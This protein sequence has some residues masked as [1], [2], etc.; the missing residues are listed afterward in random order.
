MSLAT[1]YSRAQTGLAAPLVSVEV[2]LANGL[3][4][5]SIVGLPEAAVRES[6][7]RVRAAII[8]AKF[9]FPARRI[10]VNLA[11][12]D[13]PKD[14]GR[15]DLP[16]AL[17]LLAASSQLPLAAPEGYEFV[18]ELSLSGLVRK[19]IGVLPAAYACHQA[20]TSLITSAENETELYR[21]QD[22]NIYCARHLLEVCAHLNNLQ[23]LPRISNAN[24]ANNK[25]TYP[26][27]K[28]V[29]GQQRAKRALCI[30]AAGQHHMLM[31]GSPGSGKTMLAMRLP[32]LLAPMHQ[33][34]IL[35]TC[36]IYSIANA[37]GTPRHPHARPFRNPHHTV[38]AVGLAGGGSY[39][40]P[41]EISLAH[42][43]VLFLDEFTEFDRRALEILREPLESGKITISR[44]AAQVEFPAR[45]QLIAAMNPCPKGCD[46]DQFGQCGCSGTE[47][48]S[49]RKKISAPLLD[50]I[51]LQ[52]NVPKL[53]SKMLLENRSREDENWPHIQE[54]VITAFNLQLE[55][56][57][58]PNARLQ[59]ELLQKICALNFS[60]KKLALDI[61]ERLEISAR[62]FHGILKV[63]RTL[64]D[65]ECSTD[66]KATHVTEAVSYR[67]FDRTLKL[68]Q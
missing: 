18:G 24:H 43:G 3:P 53:P 34:E 26:K 62:A 64:A 48:R 30:A 31:V 60:V 37:A 29:V 11:P 56:Q 51:D 4:S 16:I 27:L 35:E 6:K 21:V 61:F 19:T 9:K 38:S 39:P 20:G 66:I 63:A 57:G 25:P 40:R 28:D 50:R 42:N 67:Q 23:K 32:G 47:L 2:H 49:Y 22:T 33:A 36:S 52:V 7:D 17:G 45:F 55:R 12:A 8:N 10:T 13:L 46:I 15:F 65:L 5:F 68:L 41:G 54:Q 14:G 44:A 58:M 59:G 1:L